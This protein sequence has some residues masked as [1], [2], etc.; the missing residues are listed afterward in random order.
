MVKRG[1]VM[2][3]A[4]QA[5]SFLHSTIVLVET[6]VLKARIPFRRFSLR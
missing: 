5:K 4:V 6:I 1:A 3:W 2:A